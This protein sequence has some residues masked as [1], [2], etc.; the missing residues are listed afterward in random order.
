MFQFLLQAAADREDLT[1]LEET[2]IQQWT[3]QAEE[4]AA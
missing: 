1:K 2:Y 3:I 4:V